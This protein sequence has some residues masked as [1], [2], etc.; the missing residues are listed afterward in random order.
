MSKN[1]S[2]YTPKPVVKGFSKAKS[3]TYKNRVVKIVEDNSSDIIKYGADNAFPQKLIK[4]LD[5][6]GTAT[7]CIDILTQYIYANGLV[8]EELGNTMINETQTFNELIS[9][10][11]TYVSPFQAVPLYV[12]RGLDGKVASVKVLP[13]EQIRKTKQGTYIL[14]PTFGDKHKKEKDKEFPAF[15]G[16]IITPQEVREHI[17][18]WGEDVGEILY[19]FRKKPLKNIYPIPTYFSAIEDINTDTELSKYELETVINSFLASGILN[20]VGNYDNTTK[21][22]HGR[23]EQDYMDD[24]L[25]SFTGNKKDADGASGRQKLLILQAKTKEELAVFQPLSNEG[26]LNA[27]DL[28]TKRI[29]EKVSRAFGVPPFLIGLGGNVGFATNIIADNI[30]LFNNRVLVL[31]ELITD[32]LELCFT[33]FNFKLTQL[34]PIKYI[35]SEVYAK[36]TDAE[37]RAIGGYETE[38]NKATSNITLAQTLGVGGTQSLVGILQDSILTPDQKVN[39]LVIL[40]GLS[41]EQAEKLVKTNI[42]PNGIQTP[43][44]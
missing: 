21:D 22:E 13:F 10:L 44:N 4:Q 19:F 23:T 32:A 20:I 7:S 24:A 38:E 9:E 31:Q 25:E 30:M 1:K 42:Q 29:A 3:L 11:S 5:E 43:N 39:T 26:V 34:N 18:E 41:Q 40:F 35:P 33:Q 28:A 2:N 12:M 37:I 36:L 27:S 16:S 15:Y 17:L 8:N 6:S 14:N